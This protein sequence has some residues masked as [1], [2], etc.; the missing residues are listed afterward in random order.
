MLL[1]QTLKHL[2]DHGFIREEKIWH[3][4]IVEQVR[5]TLLA[6]VVTSADTGEIAE[7]AMTTPELRVAVLGATGDDDAD[8]ELNTLVGSKLSIAKTGDVQKALENGYALCQVRVPRI[9]VEGEQPKN[10]P[11]KFVSGIPEV[12]EQYTEKVLLDRA[13]ASTQRAHA[14]SEVLGQRIPELVNRRPALYRGYHEQLAIALPVKAGE[15]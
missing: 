4:G 15:S 8:R 2:D 6:R 1:E 13:L 14:T 5:E 11:A 10:K 12:V 7:K 9:L 3:A